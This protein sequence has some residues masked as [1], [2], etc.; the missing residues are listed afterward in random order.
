MALRRR[1]RHAAVLSGAVGLAALGFPAV[2]AAT[3]TMPPSMLNTTCSLDQ[4]MAAARVADPVTYGNLVGRFSAQPRWIQGGIVYHMNML[5]QTPPPQR[6][7]MADQ[8]AGR[9]P[10]FV[11]LF[12]VAD[13]VADEIA[14]KCPTYPA[15]DPA[16]WNPTAPPPAPVAA[17][18]PAPAPDAAPAPAP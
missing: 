13:P 12:T 2:A 11:A 17:P 14:A 15:E 4:V 3:N 7:A 9:F 5:L 18:A 6:Q 8:L 10:E 1:L 16:V